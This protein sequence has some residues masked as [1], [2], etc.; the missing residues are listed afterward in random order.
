MYIAEFWNSLSSFALFYAGLIGYVHHRHLNGS[1]V[2]VILA[3]VGLGSV[4]FHGV[5]SA[6]T[7]MLDEIPM[8]FLVL[9]ISLNV[10]NI[11]KRSL[12]IL[13][14]LC[15]SVFS[16]VICHTAFLDDNTH[17]HH[18]HGHGVNHS[19]N[20][21]HGVNNSEV[22]AGVK[23]GI[24]RFEFYLFQ[25]TIICSA[26]YIGYKLLCKALQQQHS[27]TLFIQGVTLFLSGW[28]CWLLDYFCCDTWRSSWINP[29]FHAWWHILSALGVYRLSLLSMTLCNAEWDMRNSFVC[30]FP[31][32]TSSENQLKSL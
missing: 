29:Q 19:H 12:N 2:Y 7:Q 1:F 13:S 31:T 20:H 22:K 21:N 16:G 18:S 15:A 24:K 30:P 3:G 9:Q 4:L 27:K 17:N 6:T 28:A 32:L 10:L 23:D 25:F 5:L 11:R 8:I 14:Y 26:L